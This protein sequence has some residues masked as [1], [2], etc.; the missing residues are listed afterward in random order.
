M[1]FLK[2]PSRSIFASQKSNP[3]ITSV[4]KLQPK[5]HNHPL[6]KHT[7][8]NKQCSLLRVDEICYV[9]NKKTRRFRCANGFIFYVFLIFRAQRNKPA[10][11]PTNRYICG[12]KLPHLTPLTFSK[13]NPKPHQNFNPSRVWNLLFATEPL[14]FH[15]LKQQGK[16]HI[17]AT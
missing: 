13:I 9:G 11:T 7:T 5:S 8:T 4:F 2:H 6:P 10:P 17:T 3:L 16:H 1:Y 14:R 15:E 12:I